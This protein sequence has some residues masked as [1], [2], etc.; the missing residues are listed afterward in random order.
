MSSRRASRERLLQSLYQQ[1]VGGQWTD[2]DTLREAFSILPDLPD[3]P[4]DEPF[5]RLV[6]EAL[7]DRSREIDQLIEEASQNW[8]L[9]RM[10]V[11]DLCV[12]RLATAELLLETAPARV[13]LNE[14]VELAKRYGTE[15][16]ATFV[17]GVLDGVLKL[18]RKNGVQ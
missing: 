5:F 3:S 18:V 9:T 11:V 16:A 7:Q 14:A 1:R 12:L 2:L 6:H 8:R 17:N 4:E 13:V 15:T 10:A